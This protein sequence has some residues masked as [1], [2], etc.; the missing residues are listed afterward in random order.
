MEKKEIIVLG[1]GISGL[2][3]LWYLRQYLPHHSIRLL[4]KSSRVGGVIGHRV[5]EDVIF[6]AGPKTFRMVNGAPLLELIH[7]VHLQDQL[8]FSTEEA[9]KRY[10]YY[11]NKLHKIPRNPLSLLCSPLTCKAMPSLF[12]ELFIKK[13]IAADETIG[14]FMRRRFGNYI[15]DLFVEP[16]VMGICGGDMHKL[17]MQAYFPTL[18]QWEEE[19]GSVLKAL[20]LT[21]RAKRQQ[22]RLFNLRGGIVTLTNTLGHLLQDDISL[23]QEAQE[24]KQ[25]GSQLE[26]RTQQSTFVADHLFLALPLAAL[27]N[28]QLPF[29]QKQGFF[30]D[31]PIASLVGV[32]LAYKADVLNTKGFGYLVPSKQKQK[33]L[34]VLFDKATF[35]TLDTSTYNTKLTVMMGGSMHPEMIHES[36]ERLLQ[37]ALDALFTHLGIFHMPDMHAVFKYPDAIPQYPLYHRQRLQQVEKNIQKECPAITLAGSYLTQ[38]A[39]SACIAQSKTLAQGYARC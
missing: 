4:E 38:A 12:K 3:L 17:S 16:M 8:I 35:P 36:D 6:D 2:S 14:A 18:K 13:G 24:I 33:I 31:F 15:A 28:I 11:N 26:V 19:Q 27:K 20:L 34:G 37:I 32:S 21:T 23:N 10:L 39:V 5:Q 30:Y 9:G 29:D 1:G 25:L 22:S 7:E